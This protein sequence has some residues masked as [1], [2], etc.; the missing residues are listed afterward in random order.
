MGNALMLFG[1]PIL[2][3]L[4]GVASTTSTIFLDKSEVQIVP[5]NI[6]IGAVL[7]YILDSASFLYW[8]PLYVVL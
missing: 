7:A 2:Q 4:L 6:D 1:L 5:D 8:H 3:S